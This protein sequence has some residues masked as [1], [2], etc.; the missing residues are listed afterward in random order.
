[1]HLDN[2]FCEHWE[3]HVIQL[4]ACQPSQPLP[5]GIR[6]LGCQQHSQAG[7]EIG[8]HPAGCCNAL[9]QLNGCCGAPGHGECFQSNI[10]Q[11]C[12]SL[13]RSTAP[14]TAA[15]QLH[16]QTQVLCLVSSCRNAEEAVR[17]IDSVPANF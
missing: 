6:V 9:Q 16:L 1:M 17:S 7:I 15:S 14:S 5:S 2:G 11:L 3:G 8:W 12:G 13:R 10:K 4:Q